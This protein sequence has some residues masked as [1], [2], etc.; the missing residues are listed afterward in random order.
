MALTLTT[1]P[2]TYTEQLFAGFAPVELL[3]KREDLAV[4]SVTSGVGTTS[5]ILIG[6]DLTSYLSAGDQVYF[7]S[8][9]TDYTY[10]Q[11]ATVTSISATEVFVDASYIETGTGGYM[12]YLKNYYVELQCVNKNNSD[13]N[14]LPFSLTSDGDPSGVIRIDVSI[15]NDLNKQNYTI[16]NRVLSEF[17]NDFEIK[18]REVH[19]GSANSFTIV[20]NKLIVLLFATDKPEEKEIINRFDLPK[21]YLGY[22]APVIIARR[23]NIE[24]SLI[25]PTYEELNNNKQ[26]SS[27]STLTSL[28]ADNSGYYMWVFPRTATVST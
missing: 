18:Y 20:D 28:P 25:T 1:H 13:I 17:Q 22:D 11:I 14:I 10:D 4:T 7:Y 27:T 6:V 3:F 5:K 8:E 2:V 23:S 12:N 9:G 16:G 15:V 24:S 19:L 21:I 26:V